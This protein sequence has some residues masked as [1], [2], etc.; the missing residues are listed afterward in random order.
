MKT[1]TIKQKPSTR[2]GKTY[3][4]DIEMVNG[5]PKYQA[6]IAKDGSEITLFGVEEVYGNYVEAR[7]VRQYKPYSVTFKLG[8]S[9]EYDSYN[10]IYL[11]TIT[12]IT[13]KAVTIVA[14]HG[15]RNAETHRLDLYKF[16]RKNY[17]F[18]LEKIQKHN[19]EERMYI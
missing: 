2:F 3:E 19:S 13:E 5:K 14:Y 6:K 9:A 10:L 8:D 4:R 12:K 11:G 7:D 1:V 16:A 18:D 17:Q 15:T